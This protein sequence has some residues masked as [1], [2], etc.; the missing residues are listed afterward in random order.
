MLERLGWYNVRP[1]PRGLAADS[2]PAQ[3]G[4][5]IE[6]RPDGEYT[7]WHRPHEGYTVPL[8]FTAGPLPTPEQAAAQH[9]RARYGR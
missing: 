5:A 6:V 8:R 2:D 9:E 7:I 4:Y 3:A 1:T